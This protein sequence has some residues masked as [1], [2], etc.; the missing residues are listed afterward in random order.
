MA[1]IPIF[2]HDNWKPV[3]FFFIGNGGYGC[4][5]STIATISKGRKI[6]FKSCGIICGV[7]RQSVHLYKK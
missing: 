5:I 1:R 2:L 4:G 3:K 6:F 7:K